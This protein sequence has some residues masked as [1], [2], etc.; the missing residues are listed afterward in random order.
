MIHKIILVILCF[1]CCNYSKAQVLKDRHPDCTDPTEISIGNQGATLT[2]TGDYDSYIQEEIPVL[3]YKESDKYTFWYK[4][5][6]ADTCTFTFS[7]FPTDKEDIY[8]FFLYKA[9]DGNFCQGIIDRSILPIRAN[10]YKKSIANSGTGIKNGDRANG[11]TISSRDKFYYQS[12]HEKVTAYPGEVYYLNVYHTSGDD[13]GHKLNLTACNFSLSIRASHKPCFEPKG[14]ELIAEDKEELE[15]IDRI[16]VNAIVIE[17]S[18]KEIALSEVPMKA[19]ITDEPEVMLKME[20][21]NPT[22]SNLNGVVTEN[23]NGRVINASIKVINSS[24]GRIEKTTEVDDDGMYSVQLDESKSYLFV[25][26]S[27]GYI[28]DTISVNRNSFAV[29]KSDKLQSEMASVEA[30]ANI[31]LNNIYFHPNTYVLE[32]AR[33]LNCETCLCIWKRMSLPKLKYRAIP[34]G[35]ITSEKI[36]DTSTCQKRGVFRELLRSYLSIELKG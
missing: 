13:C 2:G 31:V 19:S 18:A 29:E 17:E 5:I 21:R 10:L 26:S 14:G 15:Y 1:L 36:N 3:F 4:F 22:L 16:S 25:I 24:T 27:L 7:I 33:I 6:I 12:Y 9:N 35:I 34:V 11:K 30:G 8:N 20:K 28:N 23:R 32:K